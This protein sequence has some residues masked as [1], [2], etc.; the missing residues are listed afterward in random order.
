MTQEYQ[1][2][3]S[4]IRKFIPKDRIY[5][6]ELRTL[7]WGT[8]ASFYRMTPKI[9]IR[10][11]DE[12]EVSRIV[13]AASAKGLPF[14]FRAA[15]TSLSGQSV[16]DSILIVAGKNFGCG[17]SREHAAMEPRFLNVKVVLAKSFA[18]IHETN[19][20]KQGML[21]L[22]FVDKADY[23]KV[24]EDD[25][26]SVLGIANMQPGSHLQVVLT[27]KDGSHDQF[28]AQHTYNDVQIAWLKAGSALNYTKITQHRTKCD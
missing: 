12:G 19:L 25:R 8:D 28:L 1:S 14:T 16:S 26:I 15:G 22:T 9:V 4:D 24:Q 10:A 3:L 27:H 17:S 21:A 2:F 18:R 6:D 5:A 13:A 23:D 11:R 20:K 7:A